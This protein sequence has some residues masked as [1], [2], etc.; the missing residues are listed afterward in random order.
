M[1]TT[2]LKSVRELAERLIQQ[3][4]LSTNG[5]RFDWDNA[6]RRV[7][8]CSHIEKII[9]LSRPLCAISDEKRILDTILHEI[10]H[11]LVGR[12]HGHGPVWRAKAREIGCSGQVCSQGPMP[13]ESYHIVCGVCSQVVRKLYRRSTRMIR[14]NVYHIACGPKSKGQMQL[15]SV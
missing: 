12:G 4:G 10:A 1:T 9:S 13:K 11:A 8:L 7:G 2:N 14:D 5:W 15:K 6:K 3:H